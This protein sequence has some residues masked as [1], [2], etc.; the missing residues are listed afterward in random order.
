MGHALHYVLGHFRWGGGHDDEAED[1][2]DD[3]PILEYT[4]PSKA[5]LETSKS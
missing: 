1:S 5:S 3:H 2:D 4:I